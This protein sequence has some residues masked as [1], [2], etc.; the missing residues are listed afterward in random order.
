MAPT[1][2]YVSRGRMDIT[3]AY[4]VG[5]EVRIP[6]DVACQVKFLTDDRTIIRG[7]K[8]PI[9]TNVTRHQLTRSMQN[10]HNNR[11]IT[12][13]GWLQKNDRQLLGRVP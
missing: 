10:A 2:V 1:K 12:F 4:T 8:S 9:T 6:H 5:W 11:E 13:T 3:S 7:Q